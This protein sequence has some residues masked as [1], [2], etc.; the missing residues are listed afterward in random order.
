MI[1]IY[2]NSMILLRHICI[3]ISWIRIAF[4]MFIILWP[5]RIW[6]A[7]LGLLFTAKSCFLRFSCVGPPGFSV[8]SCLMKLPILS[9]RLRRTGFR[10]N[11]SYLLRRKLCSCFMTRKVFLNNLFPPFSSTLW[12]NTIGDSW[13]KAK[14]R[15]RKNRIPQPWKML[16]RRKYQISCLRKNL[17]RT[18]V[19]NKMTNKTLMMMN[20]SKQNKTILKKIDEICFW[21]Y[22]FLWYKTY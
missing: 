14:S 8:R 18:K 4:L 19:I 17:L 20:N 15:N 12:K 22:Q 11:N 1:M 3:L 9:C 21:I 13:N 5:G 2:L 6:G 7:S 10:R 16:P